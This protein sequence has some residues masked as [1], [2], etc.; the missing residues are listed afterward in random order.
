MPPRRAEKLVADTCNRL[1][2]ALLRARIA[3]PFIQRVIDNFEPSIPSGLKKLSLNNA[4]SFV[5]GD[6]V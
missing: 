3:R 1:Q 6:K 4:I 5:L 2:E